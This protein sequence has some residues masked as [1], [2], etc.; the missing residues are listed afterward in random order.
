MFGHRPMY[1]SNTGD[2]DCTHYGTYT[3]VGLP[4]VH[5]LVNL[6]DNIILC[7]DDFSDFSKTVSEMLEIY[8]HINVAV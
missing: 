7:I 5:W 3:R 6:A 1:C 8:F 2:D 4:F